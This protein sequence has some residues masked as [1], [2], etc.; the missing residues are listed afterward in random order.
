MKSGSAPVLETS[1]AD[2]QSDSL[3]VDRDRVTV[4]VMGPSAAAASAAGYGRPG[5]E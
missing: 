4:Q 2:S 3:H 1:K 5:P